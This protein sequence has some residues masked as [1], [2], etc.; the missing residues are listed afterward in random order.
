[1]T[2]KQSTPCVSSTNYR[3]GGVMRTLTKFRVQLKTRVFLLNCLQRKT[4]FNSPQIPHTDLVPCFGEPPTNGP[5]QLPLIIWWV[6]TRHELKLV[7]HVV[8]RAT[9][10]QLRGRFNDDDWTERAIVVSPPHSCREEL[11]FIPYK[12]RGHPVRHS[13]RRPVTLRRHLTLRRAHWTAR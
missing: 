8:G 9:C 11:T 13:V 2:K 4:R 3:S 12:Y 7:N 10:R 6:Y 1:M 5:V